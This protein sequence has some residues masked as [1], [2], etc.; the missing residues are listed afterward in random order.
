MWWGSDVDRT[1]VN[2]NAFWKR[3]LIGEYRRLIKDSISVAIDQSQHPMLRVIELNRCFVRVAGTV[4]DI[5]NS[6][7]VETHV[8]RSIHQWR[9]GDTLQF[10]SLWNRKGVRGERNG[11]SS[12]RMQAD[13][14]KGERNQ[15]ARAMN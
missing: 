15:H 5:E 12:V 4:R 7:R 14:K 3:Q 10:V 13:A 8:H 11:L 1:V 6:V 9:T 2:E